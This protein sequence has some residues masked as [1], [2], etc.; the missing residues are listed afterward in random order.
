MGSDSGNKLTKYGIVGIIIIVVNIICAAITFFVLFLNN[1]LLMAVIMVLIYAISTTITVMPFFGVE[2]A[3]GRIESLEMAVYNHFYNSSA[4]ANRKSSYPTSNDEEVFK[5][6][7]F[8]EK[9]VENIQSVKFAKEIIDAERWQCSCGRVNLMHTG[10]CACGERKPQYND[11]SF[12]KVINSWLEDNKWLCNCGRKN[13]EY[14]G[15]CA[16]GKRKPK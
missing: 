11:E 10:T 1:N 14:I 4:L 15:T 13:A 16:C 6:F 8:D 12:N 5:S 9:T 2:E 3:L 7:C